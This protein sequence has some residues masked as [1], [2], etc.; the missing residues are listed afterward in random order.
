MRKKERISIGGMHCATCALTI[1]KNVKKLKGVSSFNVNFSTGT[2]IADFDSEKTSIEEIKGAVKKSGYEVVE[3]EGMKKVKIKHVYEYKHKHSELHYQGRML[4]LSLVFTLPIT[5][6]SFRE[7]IPAIVIDSYYA[8]LIMFF[9]A[10]PIQF[11]AGRQFYEGTWRGIK[12]RTANMDILIALGT[13]AAYFYSVAVTFFISGHLFYDTATLIILFIVFGR[14]LEVVTKGRASEAIKKLLKLQAKT[15]HVIRDGKEVEVPLEDVKVGDI[16]V[17]RPGEK[18]PIDGT[19]TAGSSHVD[20]S[21]VTGESLPVRKRKGDALIGATMNKD[22]FLKMKATK[23]GSDT[24]LAQIIR[25]VEEAQGSKAPVQK[26]VDKVSAYFVP[27][28]IAI[29]ILSFLV[30]IYLGQGFLFSFTILIAVLIIA[31]PC[32]LG[33]ATPTAIVV[34]TGKGAQ[35]G[36]LI[37]NSEAIELARKMDVIVFDK[38]RTLTKGEPEVTDVVAQGFDEDDMLR[39]AAVAEKNSEHPLAKA[40]V[41]RASEKFKSIPDPKSF[42]AI[43]GKGI[44]ANYGGK[45]IMIGNRKLMSEN[46]LNIS[47]LEER[48]SS[49]EREGKSVVIM[50]VNKKPVG[51]F[52]IA[53]TLRKQAKEAVEKLKGMGIEVMMITGDYR[54]TAEAIASKLGIEKALSEVLPAEKANEIKKLQ[55]EGKVV[56]MAGDGINDAPALSQ[57]DIGIAIGSGTDIAIESGNIVLVKDDLNDVVAAVRLSRAT[58][59]KIKQNLFWAFFYNIAAIPVAAGVFYPI[60]ILLDPIIAALA[61]AFSSVTVVTNSIILKRIKIK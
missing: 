21:I 10:T 18:V 50:A 1:E 14:Y 39:F 2:A 3:K 35:N 7:F 16:I 22:G 42:L 36:I 48:M 30:W 15:A 6:I 25:M 40:I 56:G 31:C 55:E 34:G 4:L 9:L 41:D 54:T 5:L 47:A 53:D 58:M 8:G 24:F 23:V 57:A 49:L 59:G 32:A 29:A 33:L 38:T 13:S 17:I 43:A 52:A 28:V 11:I 45:E 19:V 12:N 61:M 44:R 20:E 37:K 51:L 46:K 26:L 27:I 60:G